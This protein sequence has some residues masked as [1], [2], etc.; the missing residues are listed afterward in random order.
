VLIFALCA[1]AL[2]QEV[3]SSEQVYTP[4]VLKSAQLAQRNIPNT[5][6]TTNLAKHVQKLVKNV[7]KFAQRI[8]LQKHNLNL[9]GEVGFSPFFLMNH[10]WCFALF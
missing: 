3:R 2:K 7:P 8:P 5:L 1:H 6:P 4:C 10:H 9:R